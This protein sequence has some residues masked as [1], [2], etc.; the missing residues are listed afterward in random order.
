MKGSLGSEGSDVPSL[1]RFQ[2]VLFGDWLDNQVFWVLGVGV[3]E[4]RMVLTRGAAAWVDLRLTRPLT[5]DCEQ[6]VVFVFRSSLVLEDSGL[7][8]VLLTTEVAS[9]GEFND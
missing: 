2:F 8:G 5:V 3:I 7:E 1:T 6:C 4:F 9:T